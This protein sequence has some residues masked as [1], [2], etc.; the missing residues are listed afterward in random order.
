MTG[1]PHPDLLDALRAHEEL[2]QL[3]PLVYDE[4]R[5]IAHRQLAARAPGAT[6]QTTGLV[7][8][9][10]L[11]LVDQSRARWSDRAHFLAV[12]SLAMRHVL[13]DRAKARLAQK[14]GGGRVRVSLDE[15]R[16]A[17]D[18]QPEALLQ[19]HEALERLAA[20]EPRLARVVECRFFGGLTQEEIAES[21]GIAVRTVERDWAKA[22]VLLRRAL[23]E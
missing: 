22:R 4:L 9:A 15:D 18:D 20:V 23:L 17:A 10:Y 2:E 8:E 11:K 21:L 14:R 3:V 6:L 12:A 13:V 19:L 7:H 1:T 16:I 5:R